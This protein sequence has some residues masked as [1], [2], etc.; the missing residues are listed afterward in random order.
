MTATRLGLTQR[1]IDCFAHIQRYIAAHG[2]SPS[3][4]DLGQLLGLEHKSG[5]NRLVNGLSERGWITFKKGVSRSIAIVPAE[6]RPLPG[7]A[8]SYTLPEVTEAALRKYCRFVLDEPADVVAD[9]V[10]LFLDSCETD[11]AVKRS[12]DA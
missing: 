7:T 6:A 11:P 3:Y 2:C 4:D 9:A 5:I 8:P 10:K 12:A 1:Q